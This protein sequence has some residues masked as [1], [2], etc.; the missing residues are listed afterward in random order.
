[1]ENPDSSSRINNRNNEYQ[2]FVAENGIGEYKDLSLLYEWHQSYS[3][4][5]SGELI[6]EN[7]FFEGDNS[8]TKSGNRVA[9][10]YLGDESDFQDFYLNKSA[11]G[12]RK[13]MD[14]LVQRGLD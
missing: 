7:K 12:F 1:V 9:Y 14:W 5:P 10:F 13:R 2:I 3:R 11:S 6:P 4:A 8:R